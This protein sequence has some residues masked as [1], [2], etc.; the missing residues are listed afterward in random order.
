MLL[1]QPEVERDL[2]MR[3]RARR[4][5]HGRRHAESMV[6]ELGLHNRLGGG[7]PGFVLDLAGSRPLETGDNGP[8]PIALQTV[9]TRS[10][11]KLSPGSEPSLP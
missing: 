3:R 4:L 11:S 1:D 5:L 2:E 7:E 6:V 8:G 9:W 10:L